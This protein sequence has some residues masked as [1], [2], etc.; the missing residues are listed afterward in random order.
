[1]G[2]EDEN[3]EFDFSED[4]EDKPPDLEPEESPEIVPPVEIAEHEAG[5]ED[6]PERHPVWAVIILTIWIITFYFA[7]YYFLIGH[8]FE[9]F[10][11]GG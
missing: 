1:M 10:E 8:R 9:K 11:I 7:F 6:A 4:E 3:L 5:L 2:T